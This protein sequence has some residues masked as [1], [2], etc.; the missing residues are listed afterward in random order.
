MSDIAH[1]RTF[2]AVYRAGSVTGGASSIH[3]SQP[4]VTAHV[5]ALEAYVGEPLF[6]RTARGT[7]PTRAGD[8]LARRCQ[9]HL[10][11][12]QELLGT[13]SADDALAHEVWIGG[14]SELIGEWLLPRMLPKLRPGIQLRTYF[15]DDDS[16]RARLAAGELDIA[17]LTADPR[18]RTL[19]SERFGDEQL[20]LVAAPAI[21]AALGKVARGA[22]GASQLRTAPMVAFD[23]SLPLID[24]YWRAVFHAEPDRAPAT[25]ANSLRAVA[26]AT[27][28]GGGVTVLPEHLA[29]PMV[30]RGELTLVLDPR[31]AP[32]K[33]LHVGWRS[34]Q[35]RRSDVAHVRE[36]LLAEAGSWRRSG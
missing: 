27:A 5:R 23:D 15:S 32:R 25:T 4:A 7:E 35:V 8:E 31:E 14:P 22:R 21:A 29:R 30:E 24:E 17:V 2:L 33:P 28:A 26:L 3:L 13:L 36:V 20:Q 10:D 18:E 19:S 34:G 9:Q 11:S 1:L 6:T 12:L 16:V